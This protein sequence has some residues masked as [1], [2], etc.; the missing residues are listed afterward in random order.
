MAAQLPKNEGVPFKTCQQ[1]SEKGPYTLD[2]SLT[3]IKGQ[4]R[5]MKEG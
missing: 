1:R 3:F 2:T 5:G 4:E